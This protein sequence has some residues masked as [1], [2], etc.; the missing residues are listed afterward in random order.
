MMCKDATVIDWYDWI[1][2]ETPE[3]REAR[4]RRGCPRLSVTQL[5]SLYQLRRTV[6]DGYAISKATRDILVRMGL[7]DRLNGWQFITRRGM[8]V[9]DTYG[10][11]HDDRYGISRQAASANLHPTDFARLRKEGLLLG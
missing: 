7:V 9:L 8:A 6:S 2:N 4:R 3:A 1:D 5:E 11:L 10:L